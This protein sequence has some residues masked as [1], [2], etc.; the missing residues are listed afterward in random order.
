MAAGA[1]F[2]VSAPTTSEAVEPAALTAMSA[3][4]PAPPW[5]AGDQR[6]MAN[7]LGEATT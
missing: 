7:G 3:K 1:M 6:G 5:P 4:S 2:A